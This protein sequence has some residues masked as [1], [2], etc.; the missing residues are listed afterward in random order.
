M[1]QKVNPNAARLVLTKN[2]SSKW[3]MGDPKKYK[4]LLLSDVAIRR[5]VM[6]R[7][8][9]AGGSRVIIER[10]AGKINLII[11]V[12]RPGMVIG[13]GGSGVEELRKLIEKEI[14]SQVTLNVEEI[15]RPDLDAHLVARGVADQI[16]RRY[17]VKRAMM[18]AVDRVM[19]SGA[20]G[21]KIICSGRIGGREIARKEKQSRGSIPTSTLRANISFAKAD[22]KTATAGVLG[23]KIWIH[24]E[25]EKNKE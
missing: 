15:K 6:E 25:D 4:E 5:L 7:L 16:E 1:G 14:G 8:K 9:P 24:K 2:W 19:R 22:A 23:V 13:R 11:Q 18:Q 12:A 17:P 3:F 21:V 10:P 20:I